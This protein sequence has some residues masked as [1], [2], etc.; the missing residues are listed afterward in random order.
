MI[1]QVILS[2]VMPLPVF[3]EADYKAAEKELAGKEKNKPAKKSGT[4]NPNVRSLHHIDDDDGDYTLPAAPVKEEKT[5]A[6]A[7]A[8]EPKDEGP[9][10]AG[11]AYGDGVTMKDDRDAEERKGFKLF[12]KKDESDEG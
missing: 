8:A 9:M 3:T 11:G 5:E 12:G 2:K 10:A 6:P 4:R 1:K 7:E